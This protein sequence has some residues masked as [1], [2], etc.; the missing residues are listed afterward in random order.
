MKPIEGKVWSFGADET[1]PV[2]L[3]VSAIRQAPATF[4]PTYS[5]LVERL[6]QL[7][8]ANPDFVL[9][10]RGQSADYKESSKSTLFPKLYRTAPRQG[11]EFYAFEL[12]SRYDA[13]LAKERE[14]VRVL[15]GTVY[16]DRIGRSE[17]AR[18]AILQHYE[19]CPTPLLDLTH[20][21]LVACSFAFA[22]QY[23]VGTDHFLFVL[24]VPQINGSITVS[25]VQAL[26][27]VRLSGVC[28]PETL[29]P[30]F[31]EG[32]LLGNYPSVDTLDEKLRY[33]RSE[34]DGALRLIAKFKFKRTPDFWDIGTR[35]L[36]SDVLYPVEDN[37]L[38]R[39]ICE[40]KDQT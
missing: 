26:Q 4:I 34:M 36:P 37:D 24:G 23:D 2:Q 8:F 15:D 7:A 40:L 39:R 28:P 25:P 14:L 35:A 9:L 31:Q 6:A 18:W 21:A 11:E 5:K 33:A 12:K 32:Y 19:V 20:S 1:S 13:L 27:V 22:G 10:M 17:L 16:K 29:R 3:T 38:C 30:Y